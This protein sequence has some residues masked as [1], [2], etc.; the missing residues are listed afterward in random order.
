MRKSR[1]LRHEAWPEVPGS[2]AT[3]R[4]LALKKCFSKEDFGLCFL[5]AIC[6]GLRAA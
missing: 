3:L 1:M 4:N 5:L 6:P 2:K